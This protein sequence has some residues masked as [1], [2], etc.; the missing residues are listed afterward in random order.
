MKKQAQVMQ[1]NCTFSKTVQHTVQ[2]LI[3]GLRVRDYLS[4]H[5]IFVFH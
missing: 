2:M 5:L 3:E 4:S 1:R